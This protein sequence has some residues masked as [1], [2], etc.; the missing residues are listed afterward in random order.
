MVEHCDAVRPPFEPALEALARSWNRLDPD[1]LAPWLSEGVRYES[2]TTELSLCGR[3]PVMDYL[4]RRV[5]RI[6]EAGEVAR[7]R[8]ELGWVPTARHGRRPCVISSQGDVERAALF[9]VTLAAD[10][11]IDRIEVATADPDPRLAEG[12]GVVPC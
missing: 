10:G 1:L 3:Q 7:I 11:R 12:S 9:L 6:E 5:L 2:A 8:A 4:R